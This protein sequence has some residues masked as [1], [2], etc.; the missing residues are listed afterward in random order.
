MVE[1]NVFDIHGIGI[2]VTVAAVINKV[3]F[4][5]SDFVNFW[6][7]SVSTM[8]EVDTESAI[9]ENIPKVP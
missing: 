4:Y 6:L 9:N 1:L 2:S 7:Y 8:K 3:V 5:V